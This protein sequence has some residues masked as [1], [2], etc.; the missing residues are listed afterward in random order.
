[1]KGLEVS[2]LNQFGSQQMLRPTVDS[3][4]AAWLPSPQ[5]GSGEGVGALYGIWW[6]L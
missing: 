3:A 6:A 2:V 4:R 1:M 5:R